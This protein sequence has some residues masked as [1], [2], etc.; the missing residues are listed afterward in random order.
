[1]HRVWV[2]SGDT[3]TLLVGLPTGAADL[4][5]GVVLRRLWTVLFFVDDIR[6]WSG[7][8]PPTSLPASVGR[9]ET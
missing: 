5:D 9:I 7:L 2:L 6:A 3:E 1:M 4:G 8:R